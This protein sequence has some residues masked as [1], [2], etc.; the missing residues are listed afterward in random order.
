MKNNLREISKCLIMLI[1][2][3]VNWIGIT[4]MCLFALV[5]IVGMPLWG[6]LLDRYLAQ[7]MISKWIWE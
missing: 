2:F 6:P 7:K 3:I 5:L 1:R 4:I